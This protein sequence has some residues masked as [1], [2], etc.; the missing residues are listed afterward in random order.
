MGS[1]T[2]TLGRSVRPSRRSTR[3]PA[4]VPLTRGVSWGTTPPRPGGLSE[5]LKGFDSDRGATTNWVVELAVAVRS[6]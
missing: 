4:E 6:R 5:D 1:D 3:L 2:S